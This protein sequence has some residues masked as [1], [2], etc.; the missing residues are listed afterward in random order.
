MLYYLFETYDINIFGYITLRA[1]LGF[2]IGLLFTIFL[3]PVFIRWAKKQNVS[4]PIYDLAPS[5]HQAKAKT[6][7]MGGIVFISGTLVATL[8][9]ANLSDKY[10]LGGIF[11][12]ISVVFIGY[13][14]DMSKIKELKNDA[15]LSAKA[16]ISLQILVA[17]IIS[18]W[19]FFD[20]FNSELNIPFYKYPIFDMGIFSIA[21][22]T[23]VMVGT[24]NAVNLTD[25]LDGLATMPSVLGL[26]T[27]SAI[28]YI[29]G[30]AGLST[31]LLMPHIGIGEVVIISTSFAGSLL[32]FLWYNAHPAEV[33]MGDS[34]SLSIGA[35]LGYIAILGKSEILLVLIGI[36]F[37]LETASV[38]IQVY[39]FKT[40]GKR[41]FLMAPI[42]H[43][44]EKK[45]WKENKIIV[46]F[47]I[48]SIMANLLALISLKIR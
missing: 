16:K 33:F 6:P 1:G 20:G 24:S 8:I 42:H 46:R 45:G 41:V 26:L 4:Q 13:I 37:V 39:S 27:F 25:G 22:W 35:F 3:L 10:V 43:H 29:I 31:Y 11:T 19:L 9:S 44:Y 32:G 36:V 15:G 34:G 7:T 18:S 48:I 2:F 28:I 14:D 38:I 5:S 40:R 23:F 30:H 21:F 47:W 17:L 12:I